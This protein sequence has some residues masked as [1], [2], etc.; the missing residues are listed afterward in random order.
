MG[1]LLKGAIDGAMIGADE[2]G[3]YLTPNQ[4]QI[5]VAGLSRDVE[6][7]VAALLA[8]ASAAAGSIIG[9]AES[10]TEDA[11]RDG[12]ARG[13]AAGQAEGHAAA[14]AE[15]TAAVD[16]VRAVVADAESLR[17]QLFADIEPQAVELALAAA[18]RIVGSAADSHAALATEMVQRGIR[19][20][21][22][23]VIRIRVN[24][25]DVG[26]VSAAV[27]TH[28]TAPITADSAIGVG[29]CVIDVE[30]G[31][32]DLRLDVQLDSLAESLLS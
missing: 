23:R 18:R 9:D 30:G 5:L 8:D 16:L 10:L 1:R 6:E 29:G 19:S 7:R 13:Y 31:V 2:V 27:S 3:R 17:T 26:A 21:G 15:L 4:R 32:M 20:A 12:H 14:M 28:H 22:G 11:R 24:P 25:D